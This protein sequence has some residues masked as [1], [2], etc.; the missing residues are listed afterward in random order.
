MDRYLDDYN[1]IMER[2]IEEFNIHQITYSSN[3][4]NMST[5]LKEYDYR[6]ENVAVNYT[7]H[8]Y[9]SDIEQMYKADHSDINEI[10]ETFDDF[11]DDYWNMITNHVLL[12]HYRKRELVSMVHANRHKIDENLYSLG[13]IVAEDFR[14]KGIAKN[15]L[16]YV[17]NKLIKQG[18][19][20][21]AGCSYTNYKSRNMLEKA[22]F[23]L[24]NTL[25]NVYL[26]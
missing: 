10:K 16:A 22:G 3:D 18:G 15:C 5:Y 2:I 8:T 14:R 23:V 13:V 24:R 21:H 11:H 6:I 19:K 12:L 7:F 17:G 4:V 1:Q 25:S 9:E 20:V 26:P